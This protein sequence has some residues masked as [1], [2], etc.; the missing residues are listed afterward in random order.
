MFEYIQEKIEGLYGHTA[1][2]RRAREWVSAIKRTVKAAPACIRSIERVAGVRERH[3]RPGN[4]GD[5]IVH[6]RCANVEII[7]LRQKITYLAEK[8][9][10]VG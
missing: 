1:R 2:S 5:P 3:L 9:F 8:A 7:D 6:I 4:V 10:V